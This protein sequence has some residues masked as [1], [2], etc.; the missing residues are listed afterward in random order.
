[1]SSGTKKPSGGRPLPRRFFSKQRTGSESDAASISSEKSHWRKQSSSSSTLLAL[2][3]KIEEGVDP[4]GDATEG[5][6]TEKGMVQSPV[7]ELPE[8]FGDEDDVLTPRP[9]ET[10]ATARPG[11]IGRAHV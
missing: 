6:W 11:Q 2:S 3:E 9:P 4:F 8:P 10:P 5:I 1:M 7:E